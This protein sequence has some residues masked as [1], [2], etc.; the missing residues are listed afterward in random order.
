MIKNFFIIMT[1]D[2]AATVFVKV[3]NLVRVE[4]DW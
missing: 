2:A 4:L 1:L 3:L